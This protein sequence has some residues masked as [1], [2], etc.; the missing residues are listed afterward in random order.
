[1]KT[2][3]C[4]V[5]RGSEVVGDLLAAVDRGPEGACEEAAWSSLVSCDQFLA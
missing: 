3:C 5:V 2:V 4:V 1:M